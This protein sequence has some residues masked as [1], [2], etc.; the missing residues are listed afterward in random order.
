MSSDD[1]TCE[2]VER[3][4]LDLKYLHRR[5]RPEQAEPFEEHYFGCDRCWELVRMGQEVLATRPDPASR[6]T[7]SWGLL[8]TAALMGALGVGLWRFFPRTE[9]IA[10]DSLRAGPA[11]GALNVRSLLV[12]TGA[13]AIWDIVPG[14]A[15]YRVRLFTKDGGLVVEREIPDTSFAVARDAL[16]SPEPHYWQVQALDRIGGELTRSGLIEVR[17]SPTPPPP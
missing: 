2:Q 12:G 13:S 4:E 15:S 16:L 6:S 3:D 7:W 1:L 9:P 8:A 11:P 5:L 14:A 17:I 10:P